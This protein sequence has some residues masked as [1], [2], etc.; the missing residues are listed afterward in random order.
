MQ[1]CPLWKH[2]SQLPRLLSGKDWLLKVLQ[3][4]I[5]RKDK[6]RKGPI[7]PDHYLFLEHIGETVKLGLFPQ[8]VL[9]HVTPVFKDI[10]K[11]VIISK[12]SVIQVLKIIFILQYFSSENLVSVEGG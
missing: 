8:C 6:G 1:S 2:E 9:A 7:I 10:F 5:H 4:Q 3:T 11:R 12:K